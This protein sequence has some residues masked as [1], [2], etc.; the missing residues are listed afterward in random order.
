[1]NRIDMK[2]ALSYEDQIEILSDRGMIIPDSKRAEH[3]LRLTNY[4]RLSAYSLGLRDS[5]DN[6]Y[7]GVSIE[8]IYGLYCFDEEFRHLLFEIIEP[9]ELR[10]RAEI[11]YQLGTTHGNIAHLNP[12]LKRNNQK[13]LSFMRNYYGGLNQSLSTKCVKHNITRYGELPIWAAVETFSFGML[14]KFYG[15]LKLEFQKPIAKCFYSDVKRF[16]GWLESLCEIRNICAHSGRIYNRILTKQPK[17]YSVKDN[18]SQLGHRQ[19]IFP[20]LLVIRQ[21]YNKNGKWC[22]FIDKFEKLFSLYEQDITLKHMGFPENWR[23]IL[24]P[25]N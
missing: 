9:I 13:H 15:N 8:Q 18:G 12:M 21:I 6:F 24:N 5:N 4:Y 11:A 2:Q 20:R 7:S 17:L 16:G 14:S 10:L 25:I 19:K 22:D 3:I 23:E 1:M